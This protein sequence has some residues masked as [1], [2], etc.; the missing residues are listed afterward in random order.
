MRIAPLA[1]MAFGL[2]VALGGSVAAQTHDHGYDGGHGDMHVQAQMETADAGDETSGNHQ[3]GAGHD[4]MKMGEAMPAEVDTAR[5]KPSQHGVYMVSISPEESEPAVN[6]MHSW[7]V[8]IA[9][10]EGEP[11][12]GAEVSVDG[13][14]P[15]HGHGLPTSP[16]V[17]RDLGEGKYRVEGVKFNMGGWWQLRFVIASGE[18]KDHVAFNVIL[19]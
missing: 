10:P 2:S 1:S 17:T 7:I 3:D 18:R 12:E 16:S 5:S 15:S 9:T 14:M 13:G 6:D 11:V 4:G 8:E 19:D